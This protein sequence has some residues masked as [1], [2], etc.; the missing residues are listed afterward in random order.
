ME[1]AVKRRVE[2][3]RSSLLW[4]RMLNIT[5]SRHNLWIW[6]IAWT[7]SR[8][9]STVYQG[10]MH[11]DTDYRGSWQPARPDRTTVGTARIHSRNRLREVLPPI[12]WQF[13]SCCGNSDQT[14]TRSSSGSAS[15]KRKMGWP[16]FLW[17]VCNSIITKT[18]AWAGVQTWP[19][20]RTHHRLLVDSRSLPLSRMAG[21]IT[22]H[23]KTASPCGKERTRLKNQSVRSKG[24]KLSFLGQ[25]SWYGSRSDLD[26]GSVP[27]GPKVFGKLKGSSRTHWYMGLKSAPD[28]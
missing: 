12:L 4:R 22:T 6:P 9:G 7:Q 16:W 19:R 21:R 10:H 1:R 2:L 17:Y 3:E 27:M 24:L 5:L 20:T 18:R 28:W 13:P 8:Y 23:W 26:L 14:A 15:T 11:K 25:L